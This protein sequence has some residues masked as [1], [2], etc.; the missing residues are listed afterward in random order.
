M[1][2]L[3]PY[4]RDAVASVEVIPTLPND[5]KEQREAVR[6]IWTTGGEYCYH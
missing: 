3:T 5:A 6:Q 1:I 4:V 2:V